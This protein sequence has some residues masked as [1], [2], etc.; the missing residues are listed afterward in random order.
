MAIFTRNFASS[1]TPV[2]VTGKQ[3]GSVTISLLRPY[4]FKIDKR[5]R[6]RRFTDK[7]EMNIFEGT[8]GISGKALRNKFKKDK[9]T[10]KTKVVPT[11]K[12]VGK[13]EAL[14]KGKY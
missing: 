3:I 8:G 9:L 6:K 4:G 1:Q 10:F 12:F 14:Y 13:L 2:P 11:N 5:G 7:Y